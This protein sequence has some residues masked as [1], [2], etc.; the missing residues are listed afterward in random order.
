[1]SPSPSTGSKPSSPPGPPGTA[2]REDDPAAVER[3][4]AALAELAARY[5]PA[6]VV[7][8][9]ATTDVLL[10]HVV[11]RTLG[12]RRHVVVA[13]LGR[14]IVEDLTPG[15]RAVLV[16]LGDP[17]GE[18]PRLVRAVTSHGGE[19]AAVCSLT[20]P[21]AD[22]ARPEDVDVVHPGERS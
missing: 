14:L 7:S 19:V 3:A 9:D 20:P 22:A 2:L 15:T 16:T 10:A 5:T 12:V 21:P 13:D 17:D 18:L 11:A 4:G 8:P 1:M 6:A